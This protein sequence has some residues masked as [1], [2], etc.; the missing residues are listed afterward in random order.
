MVWQ[1]CILQVLRVWGSPAYVK[2]VVGDKLDSRSSLCRFIGYPKKTAGYF[3]NN[4]SEQ[5]NFVSRNAVFLKKDFPAN[6]R[7]DE[8][9]LEESSEEPQHDDATSFEPPVLTD[10]VPVL[11]M[12]T[13]GSRALERYRFVGLTS[14]LDN[15]PKTYGEAMLDIDLE[16][17]LE[18][19]KFEMD[20]MGSNQA[21]SERIHS[22]TW[23]NFEETYSPVAMA[24]SIQILLAIAAWYDYEIWHM[25]VKTAFLNEFIEEEIYMDQSEGFT[26]VGE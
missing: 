12:S 22:A 16:K 10:S 2:R 5:K 18:A 23:V 6:K 21:R 13:R 26:T 7:R 1:T 3:F 17:W 4:P 25:D 19:M 8:V 20:S 9:L 24:K 14:Q 11:R 15:D